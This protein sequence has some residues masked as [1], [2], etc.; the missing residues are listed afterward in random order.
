MEGQTLLTLKAVVEC[1]SK[2]DHQRRRAFDESDMPEL[3]ADG[4]QDQMRKSAQASLQ[5]SNSLATMTHEL[6]G[7]LVQNPLLGDCVNSRAISGHHCSAGGAL[8]S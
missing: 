1:N 8:Q 3:A 4:V 7:R 2:G 5:S 6:N